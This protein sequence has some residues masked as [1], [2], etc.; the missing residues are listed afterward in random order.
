MNIVQTLRAATGAVVAGAFG[1]ALCALGGG[2][3]LAAGT[4]SPVGSP[5]API[6]IKE[7]HVDVLIVDGFARTEVR[8]TFV[9]PSATSMEALY[10]FPVPEDGAL[11]EYSVQFGETVYEGEVLPR[12]QAVKAYEE[13]RDS[14][15]GGGLATQQSY[16][17][18]EFRVGPVPPLAEV[19][20]RF[21]YY[22]AIKLDTGVGRY[23]Y[24][25]Q[26]GGTDDAAAAFWTRNDKVAGPVSVNVHLRSAWTVDELRA[27][28]LEAIAK[29]ERRGDGEWVWRTEQASGAD[30]SKDVV[31]Y[32]R[33]ADDLPGRVELIAHRPDPKQPGTFMMIVTPGIDLKPLIRGTDHVFV[34]DISGSMAGKLAALADGVAHS[35]KRLRPDDRFRIVTF[36]NSAREVTRGWVSATPSEVSRYVAE[37][38]ALSSQGGTNLFSGVAKGLKSLDA[39]RATQVIL[40]TD[41]VANQGVVSPKAFDALLRK[42]DARVFGFLMG[43]SANWPLMEIIADASGGMYDRVSTAD[44]LVGKVMLAKSKMTHEVLHD[45]ELKVKGGKVKAYDTSLGFVGKVYRGQQLVFLG[46]YDGHGEADVQLKARLTGKDTVYSTRFA[47]PEQADDHPELERMWALDR[48][49]AYQRQADLGLIPAQ[50]ASDVVRDLG[51]AFQ[52]VTE[53]TAMVALSDEAFTRRGI[54]RH[55]RARIEL[56]RQAQQRRAAAPAASHWVD[57]PGQRRRRMFKFKAPR[58]GGGG[59]GAMDPVTALLACGLASGALWRRRRQGRGPGR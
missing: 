7:H 55:N 10:A 17:R 5:D 31:L 57:D 53:E 58:L 13:E 4:L 38:K 52:I 37:V 35:L 48:V 56:E 19:Q 43:N 15:G 24:P 11:A 27:P 49:H 28:G 54:Q 12:D 1:L 32:W 50:E 33:L 51:V 2:E 39:D 59:G 26:D 36:G 3:A 21:V 29:A 45:A 34:L 18:F 30:L 23:L 20:A 9:N 8:Q 25:L 44:D 22:Q 14:G 16:Q 41:A 42:Y 46:R 47:F 40:V 6:D